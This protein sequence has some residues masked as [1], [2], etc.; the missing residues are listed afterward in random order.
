MTTEHQIAVAS[1]ATAYAIRD[2]I[3]GRIGASFEV[4]LG[5]IRLAA[6]LHQSRKFGDRDEYMALCARV[7]DHVAEAGL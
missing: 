6:Y 4:A 5:L 2:A 7:Y 3:A 1:R